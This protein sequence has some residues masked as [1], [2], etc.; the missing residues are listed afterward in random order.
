[1]RL[2][3]PVLGCALAVLPFSVQASPQTDAG[4][5]LQSLN[6]KPLSLPERQTL[7]LN[8][9]SVPADANTAPGAGTLVVE[10]FVFEGNAA[11][12]DSQLQPL[13]ADLRGQ[14][15]TLAALQAG[16]QRITDLYRA[17]GYPLARAYLPAQSVEQGQ[18]RVGILEGRYGTVR[19]E[20]AAQLRG[21]ALA[22]LAQLETGQQVQDQPLT[23]NLLLLQE[24]PGNDARATLQPG[25]STGTSDLLVDMRTGNRVSGSVDADNYGNRYI[26]QYRLG[27]SVNVNNP[28]SLGDR[29]S[30]RATGSDEDQ[31][32]GRIAYQV[33]VSAWSTQLGVAYS[34]MSYEL[35]RNFA[36]L[37]AHG[38]ARVASLFALQPLVRRRGLTLDA[39]LQ[40]DAK[41]LRDIIDAFDDRLDK[42]SRV[43]IASLNGSSQDDLWGGGVSS[44]SLAWSHGELDIAGAAKR[45]E[46]QNTAGTRGSFNKL[47]P[48]LV[49]L[50]RLPQRFSLYTQLQGQW[51]DRNLES[52]EKFYL[53]GAYGVRAYPQGEASGD[54]GWL[55]NLEL[56]YALTP[57]WQLATFLDHGQVRVNRD[58]WTAEDN[59]RGLSGT[60]VGATWAAHGWRVNAVAAW[61]LGNAE[62]TSDA[63]RSPRIWAQ[64]S[65][66]F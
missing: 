40:F 30:L 39:Q 32:Y 47:T 65:R 22:P 23:R 42:R 33:P 60:G 21:F 29:L 19:A 56:R 58:P 25:A 50:Q 5:S 8:L 4:Q 6:Q 38:N 7:E 52:S 9:P 55:A 61:K 13:L 41:R 27:G 18:V 54:Q 12:P 3:H 16:L 49:R 2:M 34:E 46:D 64:V 48:S 66:F 62:P 15:V 36:D 59:H 28:L 24:L 10:A 51:A 45:L 43:V 57:T 31:R 14:R 20:N 63:D 17:Q 53:G 11:L 26:G 44:F 1:M 35:G 37:D